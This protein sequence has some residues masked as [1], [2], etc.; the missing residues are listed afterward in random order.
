MGNNPSRFKG[1]L[2]RPVDRGSWND[3]QEF[4]RDL[5]RMEASCGYRLPT[6]AEWEYACRAGSAT[7]YCFGNDERRLGEYAWYGA[8]A[9]GKTHPVGQK[10]P[11]AW[12]LYDIHGN[13]WECV[14]DWYDRDYYRHSPIVD[15]QGPDA[16]AYRVDRG[17][18][19]SDDAQV[20]RAAFRGG[21]DADIDLLGFR[22]VNSGPSK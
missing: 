5:N 10:R 17:G 4:L 21:D 13:V 7:R 16:G 8:N 2:H 6:E 14:Q 11:N 15:P 20:V 3:A 18:S 22:C 19:W 9:G 12:A 1:D